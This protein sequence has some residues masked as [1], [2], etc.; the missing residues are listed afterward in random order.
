MQSRKNAKAE[1]VEMIFKDYYKILGLE[2]NKVTI[3]QIKVAYRDQAK[4]YHPDVNQTSGISEERFKDINEA[5]KILSNPVTKRKYDRSW[6]S[7]VKKKKTKKKQKVESTG[8]FWKDFLGILLGD[9]L[10]RKEKREK[11]KQAKVK[12]KGEN[13]ETDIEV[14]IEEAY[15]GANKKI[16][17]RAV[18]G[19]MKQIEV[20]IPAGILENEKIRLIG[21]GKNGQNGGKNGDLLIKVKMN[22]KSGLKLIGYD[23]ST[24]LKITPWEAA[25][26][27]KVSM[28]ILGEDVN[29]LV[30]PCTSSGEAICVEQMGYKDGKGKRGNLYI[31]ICIVLPKRM[32]TEEKKLYE[33]LQKIDSY[34]PRDSIQEIN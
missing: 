34:H 5:Y 14:T 12:V 3:D 27:T 25:L 32:K 21:L 11:A 31:E 13:I 30:P 26:G 1:D 9:N 20:K 10:V 23:L 22:Q 6:N 18:D 8:S 19:K 2:T 28:N 15:Y 29:I 4:K 7:K 16:S 24:S 33:A 17:L